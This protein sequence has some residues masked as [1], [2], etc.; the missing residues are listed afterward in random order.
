[1]SKGLFFIFALVFSQKASSQDGY[2]EYKWIG[3]CASKAVHIKADETLSRTAKSAFDKANDLCTKAGDD[4]TFTTMFPEN[5]VRTFH[6]DVDAAG[7][8]QKYSDL[9][10]QYDLLKTSCPG[11]KAGLVPQVKN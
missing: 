5:I 9:K 10:Q 1:M 3:D 7:W 4:Y 2:W 6:T 8:H 11:Q